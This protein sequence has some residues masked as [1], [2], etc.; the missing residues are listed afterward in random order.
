M[1]DRVAVMYL[2]KIVE[3]APAEQLY[4]NPRHAY[5]RALLECVPR[6]GAKQDRLRTIDYAEVEKAMA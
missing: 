4:R 5:T 2:G 3:M 6:L 1:S